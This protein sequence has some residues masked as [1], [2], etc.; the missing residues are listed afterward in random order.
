MNEVRGEL[1]AFNRVD[2]TCT[3]C[4]AAFGANLKP[5]LTGDENMARKPAPK[6]ATKK[7]AA[8]KAAPAKKTAPARGDATPKPAPGPRASTVFTQKKGN[9]SWVE[10]RSVKAAFETLDLPLGV[11]QS[12][13]KEL[14]EKGELPFAD[15]GITFRTVT[16]HAA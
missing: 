3:V 14:K 12:F 4:N 1:D 9:K 15:S 8:K 6:A 16:K 10:H 11:H 5:D 2:V 7:T 13:R